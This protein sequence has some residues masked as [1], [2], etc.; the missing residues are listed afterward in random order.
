LTVDTLSYLQR[1]GRVGKARAYLAN[2]LDLKPIL[3]VDDVGAVIPVDKVRHREALAPRVLEL[4]RRRIP[5][6]RKRLRMGIAHVLCEDVAGELAAALRQEFDPDE[7][8]IRPATG[9]LSAHTGPG[10]WGVFF[11]AD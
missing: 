2:V 6:S 1:S 3:S 8:L 7:I 5:A 10:A 9:V 11:Q 4:L